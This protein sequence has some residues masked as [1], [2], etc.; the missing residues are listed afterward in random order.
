MTKAVG[1]NTVVLS[2]GYVLTTAGIYNGAKNGASEES[3]AQ[4][5][6]DGTVSSFNGAT[7]SHTI[8]SAGGV[9]LFNHAAL[10]YIDGTGAAHVL[11]VGGDN[12]NHPGQKSAAVWFY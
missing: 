7:G 12:L 2:G 1:K 4:V 10:S 11:V 5:G 9:N 3:Y 8:V 6:S